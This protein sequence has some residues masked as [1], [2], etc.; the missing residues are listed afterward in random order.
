MSNNK[1]SWNTSSAA[2]PATPAASGWNTS[3][4]APTTDDWNT[5]S[6]ASTTNDWNTVP[7]TTTGPT[8]KTW[9]SGT[10]APSNDWSNKPAAVTQKHTEQTKPVAATN[11][12]TTPT[13]SAAATNEWTTPTKSVNNWS[14]KPASISQ[15]P[16]EKLVVVDN[17]EAQAKSVSTGSWGNMTMDTLGWNSSGKKPKDVKEEGKG[18]WKNGV[19]ELGDV[20]AD[21]EV[22][23]FGTATDLETTHS[24]I[25][26]DRYDNIPVETTGENI[27]EGITQVRNISL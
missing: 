20:S 18:I 6:A 5:S 19:H 8:T 12:W 21:M 16:A 15:K 25:N 26:F 9:N 1:S 3:P 17:W 10:S 27:P 13:K 23:L 14:D 4:S 7:E 24:G 2:T 11:E 22:K